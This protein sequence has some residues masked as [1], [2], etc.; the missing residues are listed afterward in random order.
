[1]SDTSDVHFGIGRIVRPY[2][3]LVW[4]GSMFNR[5]TDSM[6]LFISLA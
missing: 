4:S 6:L 5:K 2:R 1:M 3:P